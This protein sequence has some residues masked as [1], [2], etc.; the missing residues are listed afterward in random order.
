MPVLL[1]ILA[2]APIAAQSNHLLGYDKP[3]DSWMLEA[4]PVGNGA[5]GAM[6]F[7]RTD[8]ER[9]QFNHDTLWTG[10][11]K[12]TG[13]YQAFGDVFVELGHRTVTQYRRELDVDRALFGVRYRS[14]DTRFS[15]T[16]FA[17][18]PARVIV[19]R[20]TADRPGAYSGRV[21]LTDMHDAVISAKEDVLLSDGRLGKQGMH[22]AARMRVLHEGGSVRV[23]AAR[24]ADADS[25][26]AAIPEVSKRRLPDAHLVFEG[27]D[28]LTFV[29]AAETDYVPDRSRGWRGEPP[30]PAAERRVSSI[31][32]GALPGLFQDHLADH[33]SLFRRFRLDLGATEAAQ[34]ALPTDERLHAY[35]KGKVAD[36]DL[37][38]LLV[39]YG[40]YLLIASSRPGDLPANLQ[41]VWNDSN[42][43]PWRSDYHTNINVQ[44]NYWPAEQTN[45]A[46][47]H[48]PLLDFISS[49]IPVYRQRTREEYGFDVPGWTVRTETGVFGGGSFKWN[50]PGGAWYA[51]H[52]WEHYAFGRDL[53]YL[54][55]VAYPVLKE[56]CQF[57]D[58]RL[59]R[60]PDGTVVT[61]TGWSPEHGP[62][63]EAITY[64]IQ[65]VHD[66]FTNYLEAAEALGADF[67][68]RERIADLRRRLPAPKIGRWGQ[69]QEWE[70]DRD[71]PKDR[72]RHV[73]HLFALH[74]GRAIT[75]GGTPEIFRAARTSLEAR[76]DGGT[77]WS[78]AWKINFWA[79]L[80]D[81][82]R[83]YSLLRSLLTPT[84]ATKIEMNDSGGV[85][86]NLLDAHPPF[87][88]DGNLGAVSGVSEMLLQSHAGEIALL[89][90]L[91]SAWP[92]GS[93]SG[94]RARGG[95]EVD[96]AWKDGKLRT[97]TLR[98]A[99]GGACSVRSGRTTASIVVEK[100][101]PLR[102][103][104]DL[105]PVPQN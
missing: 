79:R 99:A 88:I 26:L 70:T 1:A 83:A 42:N 60:R 55:A 20:F 21:W 92:S 5:M 98:S 54:R 36:P 3:A 13:H 38:E 8:V 43:P 104:S 47:C 17:S 7:G 84:V 67:G 68:F 24:P 41:G 75:A 97:A 90:A 6:L 22:H 72:H 89:P 52:F 100:G 29:L 57:W 102:L 39:N 82:D 51:Q 78:R 4:L 2:P 101:R 18:H 50:P 33:Q 94:L 65:L 80:G 59:V 53:D 66:L 28:S 64:D 85:Y 46:E 62:E 76:G 69:L 103:D 40:R 11:E 91:P 25:V 77:G 35:H 71:D 48:R 32:A 96:M 61:P 58:A 27:C 105:R 74:P 23:V 14:G 44:M 56:A 31:T 73:S 95:F 49:Q 16:A 87:Q 34:A 19:Y 86:P 37:E 81:G 93:V 10:S 12:D 15:R 30:G 63:E 45:L 9:L